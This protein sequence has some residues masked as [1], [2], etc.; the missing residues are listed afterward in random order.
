MKLQLKGTTGFC[1][2]VRRAL[3]SDVTFEAPCSV[4]FEVNESCQT[5][6]FIA[7]RIGMIPFKRCGNG[8][9]MCLDV[10]GP[11]TV[12]A[13]HLVGE[14]F[15]VVHPDVHVMRLGDGQRLKC[16][17][18]FDV[19]PASTHAR[20]CKVVGVGM[21]KVSDDLHELNVETID[22]SDPLLAV[23]QALDAIDVRVDRALLSLAQQQEHKSFM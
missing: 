20:Y 16:E 6:E 10:R 2:A 8:K 5:D 9:T 11:A 15:D 14:A 18:T 17:V 23:N 21:R 19:R 1:N 22:G 12:T 4:R 13:A 7:H 3:L